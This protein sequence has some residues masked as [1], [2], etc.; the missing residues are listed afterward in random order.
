MFSYIF[1]GFWSQLPHSFSTAWVSILKLLLIYWLFF[2]LIN[3]SAE[4]FVVLV[5]EVG[6]LTSEGSWVPARR[7]CPIFSLSWKPQSTLSLKVGKAK[8]GVGCDSVSHVG[9]AAMGPWP[10]FPQLHQGSRRAIVHDVVPW[11]F[12]DVTNM[13]A[14]AVCLVRVWKVWLSCHYCSHNSLSPRKTYKSQR[15]PSILRLST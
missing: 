9:P 10:C 5:S 12:G 2:S 15:A 14:L 4:F 6:H 3:L 13:M 11:G 8:Q 1:N 7:L